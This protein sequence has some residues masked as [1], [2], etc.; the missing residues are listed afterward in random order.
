MSHGSVFQQ[1]NSSGKEDFWRDDLF[2]GTGTPST[3]TGNW[4]EDLFGAAKEKDQSVPI[5]DS[6]G[7]QTNSLD[8]EIFI[9]HACDVEAK[10]LSS[11][12]KGKAHE[13]FSDSESE[14]NESDVCDVEV[15]PAGYDRDLWS[16]LINDV[17]GGSNVV[18]KLCPTKPR[19][20]EYMC[21]TNDAFDHR[22]ISPSSSNPQSTHYNKKV[23]TAF[24]PGG[25]HSMD[26]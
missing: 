2:G 25:N 26:S 11:K 12:D 7:S 22:V 9:A 6:F 14:S 24:R 18:E 1:G 19:S 3:F 8:D 23:G 5:V 4:R 21:T 16:P 17:Y 13:V 15:R 20:R 10:L